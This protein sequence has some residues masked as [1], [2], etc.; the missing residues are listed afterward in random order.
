MNVWFHN[1]YQFRSNG[2]DR[3]CHQYQ[4][5]I[6]FGQYES[7]RYPWKLQSNPSHRSP[8]LLQSILLS[9]DAY[10]WWKPKFNR[11]ITLDDRQG[12]RVVT[13]VNVEQQDIIPAE[14]LRNLHHVDLFIWDQVINTPYLIRTGIFEPYVLSSSLP[15][16]ISL[17]SWLHK[18]I[19]IQ[20]ELHFLAKVMPW[21]LPW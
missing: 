1:Y 3:N 20:A 12:R 15:W 13:I 21:R 7:T 6:Q 17:F 11:H 4:E 14:I 9:L 10:Q 18:S 2:G 16:L 5:W 19:L 8:Y